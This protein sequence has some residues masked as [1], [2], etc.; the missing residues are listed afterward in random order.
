MLAWLL[1]VDRSATGFRRLEGNREQ[2]LAERSSM[3]LFHLKVPI[4]WEAHA[5]VS[6]GPGMLCVVGHRSVVSI[7][8]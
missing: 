6:R 8:I 7:A 2:I 5:C 4:D 3:L 1:T